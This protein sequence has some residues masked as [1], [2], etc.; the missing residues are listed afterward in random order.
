[1]TISTRLKMLWKEGE[2]EDRAVSPGWVSTEK[3]KKKRAP[4]GVR[5]IERGLQRKG[6]DSNPFV[7]DKKGRSHTGGIAKV[8][9]R[10]KKKEKLDY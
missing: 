2:K 10:G 7:P 8:R 9:K 4:P 6:M 3:K 1:M 5:R